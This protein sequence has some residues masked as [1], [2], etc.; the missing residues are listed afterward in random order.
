MDIAELLIL[1]LERGASDLHLT[2][3]TPPVIR[4]NGVLVRTDYSI[5]TRESIHDLI[6]DVLTEQQ[7]SAFE[8][9]MNLDFSI[10][11]Q[12]L[13]RFRVNVYY[14]RRGEG[15][16]F[17]LIPTKIPTLKELGF[18]PI[19]EELTRLDRG[20][21]LVTGPTGSGKSTTLAGMV[22]LINDES[23][24][25]II[26]I[27]DPI[28]FIHEH[29]RCIINQREVKVHTLTFTD[30]LRGA[31]REDP[32]I[33]LV[34]EL[35]DLETIQLA[36]TAAETGHL[37]LST[38]HTNSAAKTVDRIIDVFPPHQQPQVRVQLSETIEGIIAQT[39]MPRADGRGRIAAL[40]IMTGTP[41]IR[42][43]IREA[44]TFQM[45]SIIQ[46]GTKWGMQS[47]DQHL[48]TLLKQGVITW[49]EAFRA[50]HDK[51]TFSQYSTEA[52]VV[53]PTEEDEE[54]KSA[55]FNFW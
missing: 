2:V 18:P 14:H 20:L 26:T 53:A 47:L 51:N 54:S 11:F 40:E 48:R 55:Q 42:N 13:A 25:H 32:D 15:A 12:D 23:D 7:K 44:K 38:L 35:R 19:V 8:E 34:G 49:K 27:E 46:T 6:Y 21:I 45:P 1:T 3:G 33:I 17:R 24:D 39:L 10:E 37:V 29:R 30:A 28:E 22:D 50:A 43:L 52:P 41:A 9:N 36:L 31:L 4:I 5:L 16:V